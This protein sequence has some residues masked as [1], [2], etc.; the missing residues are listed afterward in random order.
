MLHLAA[1][2]L[3][4]FLACLICLSALSV[5]DMAQSQQQSPPIWDREGV[6]PVNRQAPDKKVSSNNQTG[7]VAKWE[8]YSSGSEEFSALFPEQPLMISVSRPQKFF[9]QPKYGRMYSAYND[10]AVY[11][12]F[13][14]DNPQRREPLEVFLNEFQGYPVH[15]DAASFEQEIRLSG[16]KG[17]QY[18]SK[19]KFLSRILQI[20]YTDN[21][22]YV[23]EVV[24]EDLS[25]PAVNQ[26]LKS[27]T[28]DGKSK[29][30]DLPPDSMYVSYPVDSASQSTDPPNVYK[31][32]DVTRKAFIVAKPQPGYTEEARQH[33]IEGTV[34]L[35]GVL[36]STGKV[37]DLH[38]ASQLPYGLTQRAL[39][40]AYNLRFVPAMK[41]GKY[42]SQSVQ[43]EYN[44]NLY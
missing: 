39:S 10:G 35:R 22:V 30:Q 2:I 15:L 43:I 9:E 12:I 23:F 40:A 38:V 13:S 28:L 24:G 26:F 6:S 21:H 1:R 14:F 16:F 36:S 11:L 5:S 29:G 33:Q 3:I 20:Y 31:A 32:K 41:D 44:F 25:K 4:T 34:L 8:R 42:V 19:S 17:Q 18:L 7:Q 27:L 37:T